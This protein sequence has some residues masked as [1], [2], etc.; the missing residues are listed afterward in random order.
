MKKQMLSIMERLSPEEYR[1]NANVV[2]CHL[3]LLIVE[4]HGTIYAH[5]YFIY[6][7][8]YLHVLAPSAPA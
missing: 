8:T 7:P 6:L 2:T 1:A 5:I 3:A 4:L